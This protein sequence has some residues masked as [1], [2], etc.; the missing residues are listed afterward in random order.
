M[1]IRVG[2]V[3]AYVCG[4]AETASHHA[5]GTIFTARSSVP[6]SSCSAS[7]RD[8]NKPLSE[9]FIVH[10][11]RYLDSRVASSPLP[12]QLVPIAWLGLVEQTPQ[13][14]KASGELHVTVHHLA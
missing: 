7:W 4:R 14:G 1:T 5:T 8:R 11:T 6:L 13:P 2:G 3:I 10:V 12:A 9:T